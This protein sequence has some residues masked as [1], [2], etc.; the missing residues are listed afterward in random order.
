MS[1]I[2]IIFSKP[3]YFGDPL[4]IMG[5]KRPVYEELIIKCKKENM[6]CFI[7]STKGY[8]GDGVF[9]WY[10]EAGN[11]KTKLIEK[12]AK[13]DLGYDRS[14]GISFPIENDNFKVVDNLDFKKFAWNKW[15]AYQLLSEFMPKTYLYKDLKKVETNW[16]VLKPS[17]GLKGK[18]IYIGPKEDA[19]KFTLLGGRNYIA[20][21]FVDTTKGVPG[22]TSRAHDLRV[23][24]IN[25]KAVWSHIRI[26]PV[27]Q[28]KSNMA[29]G[30]SLEEIGL[31]KIPE[32]V[33]KVVQKVSKVLYNRFDNPIYSI[34]FGIT[35][36]G[37]PY[38]FEINDQIGFPKPEM[39]N[40]DNFINEMILNFKSKL[41]V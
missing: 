1:N 41:E 6:E 25:G 38:I 17:N 34:D 21:E 8:F 30:G 10:W 19:Y 33:I 28:Y 23:V 37:K 31:E 32:S 39:I 20:Q 36:K 14:G 22:L 5:L 2:G 29:G 13:L 7:V 24:I 11:G 18:G 35:E 12:Q 27:G 9:E 15:E 26:P 3:K 16:V 4:S 40:K